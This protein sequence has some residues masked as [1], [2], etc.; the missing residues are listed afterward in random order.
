MIELANA[1]APITKVLRAH[2]V[3][4]LAALMRSRLGTSR[5]NVRGIVIILPT[6]VTPAAAM[7]RAASDAPLRNPA[8]R[9]LEDFWLYVMAAP[10][11]KEASNQQV[12]S[13]SDT[14]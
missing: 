2:A 11:E 5:T 12:V 3:T 6:P 8:R 7:L 10:L 14:F 1:E 13:N 9:R 4:S